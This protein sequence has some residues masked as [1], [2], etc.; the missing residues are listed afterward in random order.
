M[1]R[2]INWTA[3][4][5]LASRQRTGIEPKRT[6]SKKHLI[7]FQC[8][9]MLRY[10]T[11]VTPSNPFAKIRLS[12]PSPPQASGVFLLRVFVCLFLRKASV[13]YVIFLF[14]YPKGEKK[15]HKL[16]VE[17]C[18]S[19]VSSKRSTFR[20]PKMKNTHLTDELSCPRGRLNSSFD[21]LLASFTF[22]ISH[23]ELFRKL[24][25][26]RTSLPKITKKI[27]VV[28]KLP[29]FEQGA[30]VSCGELNWKP[31]FPSKRFGWEF[32]S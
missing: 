12:S 29:D 17:I 6:R 16:S 7:S 31:C 27:V 5:P 20:P 15:P 14:M 32:F 11:R 8:A 24:C 21:G 2:H 22:S 18:F 28:K 25:R 10:S 9:D 26:Q 23:L 3:H 1:Q 4:L 13:N 19:N 30:D